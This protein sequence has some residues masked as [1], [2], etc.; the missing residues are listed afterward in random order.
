[1]LHYHTLSSC[2]SFLVQLSRRSHNSL[3]SMRTM[4]DGAH[5]VLIS[6][7]FSSISYH[8]HTLLEKK[9]IVIAN[10]IG[11]QSRKFCNMISTKG[12]LHG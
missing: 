3:G 10:W 2:Y 9:S 6:T 11:T 4:C 5:R 7:L 1:M 8:C 12:N